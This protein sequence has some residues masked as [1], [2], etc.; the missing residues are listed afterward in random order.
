MHCARKVV[1]LLILTCSNDSLFKAYHYYR[2]TPATYETQIVA[3]KFPKNAA[4][5][6][7]A[8]VAFEI[9]SNEKKYK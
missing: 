4:L 3:S 2:F 1:S 6:G 9:E 5:Y 8:A 7:A